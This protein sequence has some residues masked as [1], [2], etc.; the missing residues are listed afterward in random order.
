MAKLSLT[1]A[2]FWCV[3]KIIFFVPVLPVI[4]PFD[5]GEESVHSGTFIQ[6]YCTVKDGDLPLKIDWYLNGNQLNH[7]SEISVSSV[8]RRGSVLTI[9]SVQYE[10]AGNFTCKAENQAGKT[11]YTAVLLVNGYWIFYDLLI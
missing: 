8:G 4:V 1:I 5:F 11:D 3:Y 7:F 10:H 9:E 2:L 6:V